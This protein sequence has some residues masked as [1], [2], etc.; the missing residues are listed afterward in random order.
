MDY[1]LPVYF[2]SK[3][4]MFTKEFSILVACIT[5][6]GGILANLSSGIIADRFQ[7]KYPMT[8]SNILVCGSVLALPFF[9][10]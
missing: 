7:E 5:V 2:L 9:L 3:F 4:P 8:Y 6:V 10:G 1:Y